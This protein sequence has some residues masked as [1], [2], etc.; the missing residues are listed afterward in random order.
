M[1]QIYARHGDLVINKEPTPSTVELKKP[2]GPLVLAGT[3][4]SPH[5]IAQFNAVLH[6]KVGEMQYLKVVE[7]VQLSHDGRHK[8]ITI[9]PGEYSIYPLA[10]MSGEMAR[11]VED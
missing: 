2:A 5:S 11:R 6:A 9:E 1:E 8:A 3:D 7:P 10:E 4:S